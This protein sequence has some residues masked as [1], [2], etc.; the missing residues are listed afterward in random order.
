METSLESGDLINFTKVSVCL[1]Y[2]MKKNNQRKKKQ[3]ELD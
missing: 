1:H 3:Q 2:H